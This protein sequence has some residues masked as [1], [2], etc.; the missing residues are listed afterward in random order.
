MITSHSKLTG[1]W[2]IESAPEDST[3]GS[4]EVYLRFTDDGLL[5]WGYENQWRICVI[6]YNF[7]VENNKIL[8][9]CP[10]NPRE[11]FSPFIFTEDGKLKLFYSNYETIWSRTDKKNFFDSK[12]IWDPGIPFARQEDYMSLL[13]Q[14]P[15]PL[16]IKRAKYLGVSPQIIINTGVLWNAWKYS[17][18][19][20]ATFHFEDFKY[21]LEQ[22]V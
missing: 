7:R 20:F 19:E 13:S 18:S 9:V 15:L 4:G 17:R 5:Q 6:S 3:E 21:I 22:G 8:T 1:Y 14:K 2:L 12:E 16:E 11:E 10:P